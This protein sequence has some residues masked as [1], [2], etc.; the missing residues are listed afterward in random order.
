M[1]GFHKLLC[2][3]T[4]RKQKA[5]ESDY[6]NIRGRLTSRATVAYQRVLETRLE[7]ENTTVINR[8]IA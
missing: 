1:Q 3:I 4:Y 7:G 6:E 2:M 5:K 8:V